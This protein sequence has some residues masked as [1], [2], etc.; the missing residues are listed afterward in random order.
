MSSNQY[1]EN[2]VRS[3]DSDDETLDSVQFCSIEE[4]QATADAQGWLATYRQLQAGKLLASSYSRTCGEITLADEFVSRQIEV[5]G[6]TPD[7]HITVVVP[8]TSSGLWMNGH[9]FNWHGVLCLPSGTEMHGVTRE[10]HRVLSMHVPIT[11][12]QMAGL[13][14][15]DMWARL[16]GGKT[17]YTALGDGIGDRLKRLM[18]A[19]IHGPSPVS[20]QS[21]ETSE[22]LSGLNSAV[23]ISV[24]RKSR[25]TRGSVGEKCRVVKRSREY[26]EAH[27]SEPIRIGEVC[28]CAATSISKLERTFQCE[29]QMSPSQYILT[30]RLIAA[31]RVLKQNSPDNTY[32]TQ[33]AMEYGFNHLGRFAGTYSEHFGELPSKTLNHT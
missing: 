7:A 8:I 28:R 24:E 2:V 10:D 12:L 30:R 27:L 16:I 1:S 18:Y 15:C 4:M 17:V 26:I 5:V 25:A 11:V 13:D 29:L 19:A 23:A 20:E 14:T 3:S 9:E 21:D 32:V 22:L 31:N 6:T 33:V